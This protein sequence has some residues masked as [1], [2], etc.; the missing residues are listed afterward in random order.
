MRPVHYRGDCVR[1]VAEFTQHLG[2]VR[3]NIRCGIGFALGRTVHEDRAV[4][5][6]ERASLRMMHRNDRVRRAHLRIL[7]DI[8]ELRERRPF[9]IVPLE[10]RAPFGEIARLEFRLQNRMERRRIAVTSL[11]AA[12]QFAR[13]QLGL[14]KGP[15]QA[16]KLVVRID[17]DEEENL[18]IAA[19]ISRGQRIGRM[20]AVAALGNLALHSFAWISQA[21]AQAPLA[22]S[23]V[24]TREP[25]PVRSRR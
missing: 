11:V 19:E 15:A 8:V 20:L 5:C 2:G 16:W 24:V 9:D 23:E 13:A 4:H 21:F 22:S 18:A 6:F 12:E 17:Q 14:A 1:P 7:H 3:T 25:R 10:N